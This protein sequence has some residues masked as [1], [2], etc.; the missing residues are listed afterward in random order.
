LPVGHGEGEDHHRGGIDRPALA[1][2]P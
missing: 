1:G 2:L